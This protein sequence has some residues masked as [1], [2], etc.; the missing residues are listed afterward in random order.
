MVKLITVFLY[1]AVEVFLN[2]STNSFG[3]AKRLI[4]LEGGFSNC[5]RR[6]DN[7]K[8]VPGGAKNGLFDAR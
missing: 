6:R 2:Y 8:S 5:G 1:V 3:K 7:S 4:H